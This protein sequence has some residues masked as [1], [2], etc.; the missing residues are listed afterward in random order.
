MFLKIYFKLILFSFYFKESKIER[1]ANNIFQDNRLLS[2]WLGNRLY[3]C[4]WVVLEG[5]SQVLM[6][7]LIN[8]SEVLL[9]SRLLIADVRRYSSFF[10]E[11][12]Y[13]RRLLIANVRRYSS[14]FNELCYSRIK[15]EC[16]KVTHNLGKYILHISNYIVWIE[17][18]LSHFIL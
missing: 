13:S 16:N 5:D 18:D 9:T 12:C 14:V 4:S 3:C 8:D 1:D 2:F 15:R 6:T 17:N 11:L 10:N 7:R